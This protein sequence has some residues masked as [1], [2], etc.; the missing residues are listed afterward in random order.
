MRR[1]R[2]GGDVTDLTLT[3]RE[4]RRRGTGTVTY[5][6]THKQED[7]YP[8]HTHFSIIPI[9]PASVKSWINTHMHTGLQNEE[10][11]VPTGC[12]NLATNKINK[13][14]KIHN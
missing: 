2:V 8:G 3:L 14:E 13:T 12:H 9:Q 11:R 1:K 6:H 4:E 7:R 10:L 5:T